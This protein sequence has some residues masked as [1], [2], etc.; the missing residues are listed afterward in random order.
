MSNKS[1]GFDFV[2][3]AIN[4][5]SN[6]IY[7]KNIARS[8]ENNRQVTQYSHVDIAAVFTPDTYSENTIISGSDTVYRDLFLKYCLYNC[9]I[10]KNATIVLHNNNRE[11]EQYISSSLPNS[12]INNN[13]Y[14]NFEPIRD[15]DFLDLVQVLKDVGEKKYNL[16]PEFQS[17]LQVIYELKPKG[18]T[19][20]SFKALLKCPVYNISNIFL[21]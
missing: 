7:R 11:L 14:K 6:S 15:F 17:L 18:A 20:L 12:R 8:N 1:S 3:A 4:S 19:E 16:L 5:I 13:V 9:S 21:N 10:Q 2:L